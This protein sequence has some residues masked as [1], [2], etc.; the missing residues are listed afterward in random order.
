M[1]FGRFFRGSRK[2]PK[3]KNPE[4]SINQG[5]YYLYL[6]IILQ[7]VFVLGLATV[8]MVIGKVLVT[9]LWVFL[10]GFL[11]IAG[12]LIYI[13]RKAKKQLRKLRETLETVDLSGRNYEISFM[14]GV[15]TM[16]VEQVSRPLLE[17]PARPAIEAGSA[18]MPASDPGNRPP[19]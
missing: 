17:P 2:P 16:R 5:I 7:V 6:I 14:G 18:D 4:P 3:E 8:I 9:P 12:G 13:Y 15:L 10:L 19:S 1:D 11:M